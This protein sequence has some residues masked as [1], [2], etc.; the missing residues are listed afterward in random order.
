VAAQRSSPLVCITRAGLTVAVALGLTT[1][2][3]ERAWLGAA[4]IAAIAPHAL[5]AWTDHRK[6]PAWVASLLVVAAGFVFTLYAV[7]PDT[8]RHGLPTGE[9][10]RQYFHDL[11]DT[12]HVLR[13]AVVPVPAIGSALLL[14]LVAL[15]FAGAIAEW[16]ARRYDASL[17]A[18]GPSLVL[19]VAIAALAE[20]GWVW[21]TITYGAAA[22]L[23][24]VALHQSEMTERR[25]WFHTGEKR[26][27]KVLQGGIIGALAVVLA[28]AV[29]APLLPGSRSDAWFDY[30]SLGK[31][32]NSGLL[33]ATTPI[34][35]IQAKLLENPEHEVFTVDIG[36]KQPVYWRVIALDKYDGSLWTLEDTGEP[37]DRLTPPREPRHVD[38]LVQKFD[39][40]DSD[41]HWLPAAYHPVEINLEHALVVDN[42]A[43]V[44]LKPDKE[45]TDLSYQVTSEVPV[46][47]E[48]EKL[49]SP[50]VTDPAYARDIDLPANFPQRVRDLARR[51][52]ASATTPWAQADA[53]ARYLNHDGG[54]VYNDKVARSHSINTL[55]DFLFADKEG[56]CEQFASA[57]AA[58]ARSVGLPTRV[59]VGYSYGT[60]QD[61]V[62]HVKNKDAHAWPE[63]YFSGLGWVPLEPTPGRGANVAGGTGDPSVS[64]PLN[65]QQNPSSSSTT[66]T[67]TP[68]APTSGGSNT[69]RRDAGGGLS[70]DSNATSTNT[71]AG[72]V[73]QFFVA[74][75]VLVA[76]LFL[77]ALIG[78]AVLAL[79]AFRRSW[80]RRHAVDPRDR[81]LGAWAQ[82]LEHLAEAGV[83]PKPSATPVEFAL[84]HA[85]A[86]GAGDAG[87]ALMELAQLQTAAL[88]A[89]GAPTAADAEEAWSKVDAI[90]RAIGHQISPLVRWR[91]RLDPRRGPDEPLT[92]RFA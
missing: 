40:R 48:T 27:S 28:A 55:E 1:V 18:I 65:A 5:L 29:I 31:G 16:S 37:A 52:T 9:T 59:A 11:G 38:E 74:I 41:P 47:S 32:G 25:S 62:W 77:V 79:I 4:L 54:F 89:P 63:V 50:P 80:H 60:P 57:F 53:I 81:V 71:T 42:S 49:A 20:G 91:R 78:L 66:A 24:L 12:P 33:K 76:V 36:N 61:G 34:V 85:P 90:D 19:F 6:L 70:I 44:Y 67:T 72:P 46:L 88:F 73:Q 14:A 30:R 10:F 58:M 26:Q 15:W 82:A 68:G 17:G 22:A 64:P 51:V 84:R 86:H 13:T 39:I 75:A 87:P 83:E 8:T 23:Y 3:G 56:Y 21:S 92:P 69:P 7:E 2:F 43:T 45:I 35:S